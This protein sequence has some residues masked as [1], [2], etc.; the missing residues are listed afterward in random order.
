[1]RHSSISNSVYS[2][3]MMTFLILIGPGD[4]SLTEL[5]FLWS[6]PESEP[7]YWVTF[8]HWNC[9]EQSKAI[10]W[11]MGGQRPKF[12][13]IIQIQELEKT[14]VRI[15]RCI[16]FSDGAYLSPTG[17]GAGGLSLRLCCRGRGQQLVSRHGRLTRPW[18]GPRPRTCG[19]QDT[20]GDHLDRKGTI[21]PEASSI[22]RYR[23]DRCH[24]LDRRSPGEETSFTGDILSRSS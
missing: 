13:K 12:L 2:V 23:L 15:V 7:G 4:N 14:H 21:L 1:M 5:T 9:D 24:L 3:I 8:C 16:H 17:A 18:V 11:G 22:S 19:H 6:E 20:A 10:D